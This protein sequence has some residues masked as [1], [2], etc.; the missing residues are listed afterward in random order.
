MIWRNHLGMDIKNPSNDNRQKREKIIKTKSKTSLNIYKTFMKFSMA[1]WT[2]AYTVFQFF[3]NFFSWLVCYS[4]WYCKV[5]VIPMMYFKTT[6]FSF[7]TYHAAWLEFINDLSIF[8]PYFKCI[9]P[10]CI[11]IKYS[12]KS[13][14]K[15][16]FSLSSLFWTLH[17]DSPAFGLQTIV[18]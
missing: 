3:L 13:L 9:H 8:F 5:L 4:S 14:E 7:P 18:S 10:L 6:F 17:N 11:W 12:K 1:I 2:K 15:G 16:L